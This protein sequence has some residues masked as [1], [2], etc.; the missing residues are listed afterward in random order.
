MSVVSPPS[1]APWSGLDIRPRG[2]LESNVGL[3]L[4][5]FGR[6]LLVISS[7]ALFAVAKHQ[8]V[9]FRAGVVE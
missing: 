8:H 7:A 3:K 4:D 2:S 5:C 1:P 9:K 6:F